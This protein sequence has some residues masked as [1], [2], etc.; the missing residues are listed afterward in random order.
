VVRFI[1]DGPG[2][3]RITPASRLNNAADMGTSQALET[4]KSR[5]PSPAFAV[6]KIIPCAGKRYHPG[7]SIS[8]F[9]LAQIL[10]SIRPGCG[11][12]SKKPRCM[13]TF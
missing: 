2:A 1:N 4:G 7:V 13:A 9:D 5:K 6:R 11:K 8:A 3:R 12:R 10:T